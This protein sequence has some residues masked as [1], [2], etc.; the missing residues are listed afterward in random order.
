MAS[1]AFDVDAFDVDAFSVDAFDL[2]EGD[3]PITPNT[4]TAPKGGGGFLRRLGRLF[5][6]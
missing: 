3:T 6:R 2:I 4:F 1:P 5:R